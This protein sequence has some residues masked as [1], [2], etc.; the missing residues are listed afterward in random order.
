MRA[1]LSVPMMLAFGAVG[2]TVY[3]DY[4][5][6]SGAGT[7]STS[8][9]GAKDAGA[10]LGQ[11]DA[12]SVA[13][14][15]TWQWVNPTPASVAPIR[16]AYGQ[17]TSD[18]WFAGDGGTVLHWDGSHLTNSFQGAASASFTSLF[19][20][21][22]NDVWAAGDHEIEHWDGLKWSSSFSLGEHTVRALWGASSSDIWAAT[23]DG[24]M[25]WDGERW[26]PTNTQTTYLFTVG[27]AIWGS[28]ASDVWVVGDSGSFDHF[29]GTNWS[30]QWIGGTDQS[31][32]NYLAI[33]GTASDDIWAVYDS[34]HKT[35]GFSHYDGKS[36]V[37]AQEFPF[38]Q[39]WAAGLSQAS[40]VALA[41]NDVYAL[42]GDAMVAHYD[43]TTWS[44][45]QN[46]SIS[47]NN[48]DA[49]VMS[50][51]GSTSG[52]FLGGFEGDVYQSDA[53][54][55]PINGARKELDTGM[56]MDFPNV[57]ASPD[58]AVWA[59]FGA[60]RFAD[61]TWQ[62]TKLAMSE[63]RA[64]SALSANDAWVAGEMWTGDDTAAAALVH[65]NGTQW[66][67]PVLFPQ[68]GAVFYG[69]FMIDAT[70]G[71]AVGGSSI[72]T[73]NGSTWSIAYVDQSRSF[74]GVWA[75]S[76]DDVWIDSSDGIVHWNGASIVQFPN[77]PLG[78][79]WNGVTTLQGW[80]MW[81][82]SAKDFWVC[83]QSDLTGTSTRGC[84]HWNGGSWSTIDVGTDQLAQ[85]VWGSGPSDVW[86]LTSDEEYSTAN[87]IEPHSTIR[88]FDGKSVTSVLEVPTLLTSIAGANAQNIWAVGYGGATLQFHA[89]Q[90]TTNV[91]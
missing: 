9:S 52:I 89:P 22:S 58:G 13:A 91:P 57:T 62:E 36:W 66:S 18:V 74:S 37:I 46:P 79:G 78:A 73:W 87:E 24:M 38:P 64:M 44:D 32:D 76:P 43:G 85:S 8:G 6:A 60:Y 7:S 12:G 17:S 42:V 3:Q 45:A 15:P 63:P 20:S 34:N 51:W 4:S 70:H 90:A 72:A 88:H 16:A 83:G 5:S 65:W 69:I 19:E 68:A 26:N 1:I 54:I 25:H 56:R 75:S 10:S 48:I 27:S 80:Q 41:K 47:G 81:G 35:A 61:S 11:G 31:P 30:P 82:S 14:A 2:C 84:F 23:P 55:G 28:S 33:G 29:D 21:A 39:T 86:L 49:Q 71:V 59:Y 50:M 53:S 67:A 77:G 40:V